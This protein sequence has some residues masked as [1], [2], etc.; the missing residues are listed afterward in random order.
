MLELQKQ[1]DTSK[2]H[3]LSVASSYEVPITTIKK[4]SKEQ[5]VK[6]MSKEQIDCE[7]TSR[8][9]NTKYADSSVEEPQAISHGADEVRT[10]VT[11]VVAYMLIVSFSGTK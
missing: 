3:N 1:N 11:V 8:T 7:E 6:K 5:I 10:I 4:M 2:S 9:L